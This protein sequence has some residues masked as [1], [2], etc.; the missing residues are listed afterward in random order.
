VNARVEL[1]RNSENAETGTGSISFNTLLTNSPSSSTDSSSDLDTQVSATLYAN[2]FFSSIIAFFCNL[3]T[4]IEVSFV[5]N[6]GI[7]E[8]T[9]FNN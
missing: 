3:Q 7:I 2:F 4:C 6:I 9:K 8:N 5:N 1:V